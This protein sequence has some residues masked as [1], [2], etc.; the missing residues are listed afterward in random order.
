MQRGHAL[1]G[2][3]DA[4][5]QGAQFELVPSGIE[6]RVGEHGDADEFDLVEQP[7][8]VVASPATGARLSATVVVEAQCGGLGLMHGADGVVGADHGAHAAAHAGIG[9][10]GALAYAVVDGVRVG[11]AFGEAHGRVDDALPMHAK[12]DGVHRA[13]GGTATAQ[14]TG[15]PVPFDLPWQVLHA[16]GRG[17]NALS[18][19]HTVT[20]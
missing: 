12:L 15:G 13:H 16:Q 20:S 5:Q 10:V 6:G 1:F 9:R 14:R 4:A 17:G 19:L 18:W 7:Q 8:R 11:R 2:G 3:Q